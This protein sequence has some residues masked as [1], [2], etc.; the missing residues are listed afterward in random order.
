MSNLIKRRIGITP[1][2]DTDKKD[3]ATQTIM[4]PISVPSIVVKNPYVLVE[5]PQIV[6]AHQTSLLPVIVPGQPYYGYVQVK[7]PVLCVVNPAPKIEALPR[8]VPGLVR[9]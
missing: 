5:Q 2:T 7:N 3:T 9:F 1:I 6:I 4:E 8:I